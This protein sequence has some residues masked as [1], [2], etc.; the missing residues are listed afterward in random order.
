MTHNGLVQVIPIF[1]PS[2]GLELQIKEDVEEWAAVDPRRPGPWCQIK[3][4]AV[5][6]RADAGT[7]RGSQLC[8]E[9]EMS[10]EELQPG[11]GT[12]LSK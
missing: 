1:T 7:R 5:K 6:P 4:G 9:W 3:K 11:L 10:E 2:V 8:V 12:R